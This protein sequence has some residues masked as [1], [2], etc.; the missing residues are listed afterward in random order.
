MKRYEQ[1]LKLSR[2]HHSSLSMAQKITRTVNDGDTEDLTTAIQTVKDYFSAELKQ[3][4]QHEEDTIFSLILNEYQDH[5][6]IVQSL[7]EEHNIIRALVANLAPSNAVAELTRF[8]DLL[9][10]HT[11]T[12][13]RELFPLVETLFTQEQLDHILNY[14]H[15]NH[16]P[17]TS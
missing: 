16:S 17:L 12:E 11:R 3:H 5:A 1:L 4:F 6:N 9:K 13:E 7:R 2:E 8:A 14:T 10:S 15:I